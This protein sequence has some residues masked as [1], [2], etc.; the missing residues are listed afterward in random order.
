MARKSVLLSAPKSEYLIRVQEFFGGL[1]L[2][3]PHF[4]LKA[5]ES[6][7]IAEED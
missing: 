6:P 7:E 1:N 3:E 5:N 4:R 2:S